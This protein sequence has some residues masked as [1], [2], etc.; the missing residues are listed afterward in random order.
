MK[1]W[2]K[3]PIHS[4]SVFQEK[5]DKE[6]EIRTFFLNGKCY[7]MAIFSQLDSQTSVDFRKYNLTTNNRNVPYQLS[8]MLEEKI[9]KLMDELKLNTGSI[10]IIKT[11]DGRYVFLEVNPVGQYGMTSFPCNYHLD[12][13]IAEYLA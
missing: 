10:D 6:L 2:K 9:T 3:Y 8:R 13:K 4:S 12:R 7:S 5:L 1:E 11:K